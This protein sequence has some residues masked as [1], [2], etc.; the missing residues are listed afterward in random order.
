[1][2]SQGSVLGGALA[3]PTDEQYQEILEA[4]PVR[5][6]VEPEECHRFVLLLSHLVR[7]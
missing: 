7:Y 1:M 5:K 2:S 6:R 3:A 4:E